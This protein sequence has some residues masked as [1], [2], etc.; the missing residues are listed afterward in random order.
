MSPAPISIGSEAGIVVVVLAGGSDVVVVLRGGGLVVVVMLKVEI[1]NGVSED[2]SPPQAAATRATAASVATAEA[3]TLPVAMI[4][5]TL[6][7]PGSAQSRRGD[8]HRRFR[9]HR[10]HG[11]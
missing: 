6:H 2:E 1:G 10:R 7:A 3:G 9:R 5:Q 4:P 11:G 8:I